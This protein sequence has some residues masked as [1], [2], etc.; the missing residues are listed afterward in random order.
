MKS[1]LR[2][3]AERHTLAYLLS[4]M[5]ILLGLSTLT[6]IKRDAWPDVDF[7]EMIIT[8]RYPG[9]S[10]E[11]VELNVTN[12]IEDELKEVDGIDKIA[13]FSME[14]ISLV[15]LQLDPDASDIGKV[16]TDVRDA[17]SRVTDLPPEVDEA[18]LV[19]E[20]KTSGIPI[21][22]VGLTGDL[23]YRDLR[24]LARRFEKKLLTVPGVSSVKKFGY[25][26][27]EIKVEVSSKTIETYQIPVREIVTAIQGQNIRATAGSFESY[28]SEKNIVT[29]AQF[30]D[31]TE[32]GNVIVRTTFEGPR[33]RVRDLAVV[34]DDFEP[35]KVRSRI[36]GLSAISFLV[37]K[38]ESA[39]IIRTVDAVKTL[40]EREQALLP[41][42]VQILYSGDTS[43]YVR[44][45]LDVVLSNGIIGLSL[46]MVML[47]IFLN[48]RTA[49]WVAMGLPIAL[50]GAV[51]FLPIFGAFLD[52][53]ALAGMIIVIGLIVDD[54]ILIAENISRHREMG[55]P[56]LE[57]A[58]DGIHEVFFPV[59]TTIVTTLLAFG[60]MFFMTGHM[61]KFI[62][63]IPLVVT[64]ALVISLA[65]GIFALPAHLTHGL[66]GK[67]E[68]PPRLTGR[69]WFNRLRRPFERLVTVI[70]RLRY[71]VVPLFVLLLVVTLGYAAKYMDF[72]LFP[73]QAAD[74]FHILIELPT[75]ASL[76]AT[77]DKVRAMEEIVV[78]LPE[79]ELDSF[80]T[81]IG[82]KN[83]ATEPQVGGE[84][85]NWAIITVYLTPFA[86]RA[87]NADQVVED[88]RQKTDAVEGV[89]RT[90]YTIEAGGP[91]VGRPIVI[92]VVGSDDSMRTKLTDQ[93]EALLA[94]TDGVKDINRDDKLGKEQIE[95]KI[96][97][98][99]LSE[100]GLTVAGVAQNLRLAYDGEVVTSVR[101][102]DEDVDFRVILQEQARTSP[103]ALGLLLIPNQQGRL[104]RLNEVAR[105]E[106]GPG[107]SNFYHFDSERAITITA[108][109]VKGK[110]TSLLATQQVLDRFDLDRDWPGMRIVVGGEAEETHTSMISLFIAFAVAAVGIYFV[111]I[112]LFN[113]LIQ[114][115]LVMAVVPF[116][117]IGVIGAF[118]LHGQPLGFTA[119][120]GVIGLIGVLVNDSLILV[121]FV[122]ELR[123]KRPDAKFS[124]L[125]VEGSAT[126]LRPILITSI[127]T[128]AGLLPMAYG[129]GGSDPFMAPMA[130]AMGYGILLA[131]PLTLILL[132]SL[133]VIQ[134]DVGNLLRA[135]LRPFRRKEVM[136]K[137]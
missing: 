61:G 8:T 11:D 91:P 125:V 60:P 48:L 136:M 54:G 2:F 13:S 64:L 40:V 49:F 18:P 7:Y 52:S 35:E 127:T 25:L 12:K 81:R 92:R 94:S 84:N 104:I 93:V 101:Y 85:E 123:Q 57:A 112:L 4:A 77:S 20:I 59:L 133:L 46:I 102:G 135:A 97:Y 103:D 29:L 137:K 96:N 23:P 98:N 78:A 42:S 37:K 107:P 67:G 99:R 73:A 26:A 108:D 90:V 3:F 9:A 41:S 70:L 22:E 21:I 71:A 134:N 83:P 111:L 45:R 105:F 47:L 114:P 128:I 27:R 130:L 39:D 38:K 74:T 131:T 75:G 118:A 117:M 62:F 122:N 109:I 119:M 55:K 43:R 63:V 116:G 87:R 66:S 124:L 51:F 69:Q 15:Q 86:A 6:T 34:K 72:V 121:N 100:L 56:P 126:R 58:V 44:N 5:I 33:I 32:V 10:P 113:S 14:N 89:E 53:I 50:L 132:P 106:T 120:L 24:E 31:P 30:R 28:T 79:E 17:V 95:I 36:N 115:L 65:E 16:K 19:T 1:F 129:L 68:G 110:T 80:T 82:I 88:L 76:Q